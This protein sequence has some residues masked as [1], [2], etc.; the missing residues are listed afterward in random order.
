MVI[1]SFIGT[2]CT[3]LVMN[4]L[5]SCSRFSFLIVMISLIA[6]C[7]GSG[8]GDESGDGSTNSPTIT[9]FTADATTISIGSSVNLTAVFSDG[10]GSI[11]NALG[12]VTSGNP[13]SDTPVATTTY[14]LTVTNATGAAVTATA[15]ATVTVTPPSPPAIA[16][17]ADIVVSAST[18]PEIRN[19]QRCSLIEAIINA[20][21][22]DG[23]HS[24][25]VAGSGTDVIVLPASSTQLLTAA[26]NS[27]YG[28]TGLPVITSTITIEGN[29]S[30]IARESGAPSFRI[31]A[32]AKGA[33]LHLHKTN[34]NGGASVRYGD[35]SQG[36]GVGYGSP[37]H[38]GG[39]LN[40]GTLEVN[41]SKISN[42]TSVQGG[43]GIHSEGGTLIVRDSIL[44][45]NL[46]EGPGGAISQV[47]NYGSLINNECSENTAQQ[48]GGCMWVGATSNVNVTNNTIR[49]NFGKA[50]GGLRAEW[51]SVLVVNNSTV[52]ENR[53]WGRG[54]G[55]SNGSHATVL[56]LNSTIT[57]NTSDFYGGGVLAAGSFTLVKN[58]TVS[59][60]SA[61]RGGGIATGSSGTADGTL[62]VK[63]STIAFNQASESGGGVSNLTPRRPLILSHTLITGNTA[64]NQ[65]SEVHNSSGTITANA[66]NLF[67]YDGNAAIVGLQ[68][69]TNDIVPSSSLS[70][71]LDAELR[72]NGGPTYTHALIAGSPAI[73]SGDPMFSSQPG[74]EWMYDQRGPDFVRFDTERGKVDIGAFEAQ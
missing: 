29:R 28:P 51:N 62:M 38:G 22:D 65:P 68:I 24:D 39:V 12:N 1:R 30:T 14:T 17:P 37:S 2:T 49:G 74:G 69:G 60:N 5:I 40:Y 18:P 66:F 61:P 35:P 45:G 42:N 56:V 34:I 16:S 73:D 72:D 9:S 13:I 25:C 31:L 53:A 10:T 15:T 50:G 48:D 58:S 23:T 55:V 36:G 57:D 3:Y 70:A 21:N 6:A 4:K 32:V 52:S 20:N 47:R 59:G 7:G 8:S 54:G 26:H 71:I 19:D 44:L 64:M 33:E 27:I 41:N 46:A 63:S 67:G 43:G 11:D